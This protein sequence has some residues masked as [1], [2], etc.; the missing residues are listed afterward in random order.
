MVYEIF[1][2]NGGAPNVTF[3]THDMEVART[4]I[5]EK[6]IPAL[7]M[8]NT[9]DVSMDATETDP[10]KTGIIMSYRVKLKDQVFSGTVTAIPDEDF[11]IESYS[12]TVRLPQSFC[13][14]FV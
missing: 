14:N 11:F 10:T 9:I 12:S 1:I 7:A 8:E 5:K 3:H 4:I 2:K 13:V 6:F